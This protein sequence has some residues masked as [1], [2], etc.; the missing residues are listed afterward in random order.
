[1]PELLGAI[2][3]DAAEELQ[4]LS[5]A[6][7]VAHTDGDLG[8][9]LLAVRQDAL[10]VLA[11]DGRYIPLVVDANGRLYVTAIISGSALP[12]PPT[13]LYHGKKTVAVPGTEEALAASQA[14]EA[15]W[16]HI[17]AE[18]DNTGYVYVGVNGVSSA[19]GFLLLAG[20]EV[21]VYVANLNT[22]YLDVSVAG[23]GVYYIAS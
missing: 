20:E 19:D 12:T 9:Q 7:G 21:V 23:D 18:V 11:A 1:M 16:V 15:G 8:L 5:H 13:N 2:S 6:E 3:T 22:I 10:A 17:K 4:S 14:L